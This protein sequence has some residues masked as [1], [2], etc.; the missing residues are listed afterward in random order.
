MKIHGWPVAI[1]VVCINSIQNPK[2]TR[3][4]MKNKRQ[5]CIQSVLI[6]L[7]LLLMNGVSGFAQQGQAVEKMDDL[8]VT[9]TKMGQNP[10]HMTGSVTVISR[11]E[12]KR[13][14]FTDMTE[15]LRF[16]PSVEFKQ[17]GGPG[18]FSYPKMRGY[19]QGHFLVLVNGM[20]IN[21]AY[22]AGVGNFLGHLDT[23]LIDSVEILRGP[24][25]SLYG[26]DTT[27][28]VMA[29]NTLEGEPGFR[30]NAGVEYGS[31]G[32]KKGY[33]TIRG[34]T[35]AWEYALGAVYTDSEGVHDDEYYKNFSPTFKLGWHPGSVDVEFAY[36]YIDSEFQSAQ[37]K[38]NNSFLSSRDEHWAFQTPDPN[39]ANEYE[40]HIATLN[41]SQDISD[42]LRH[43]MVLGWFE[44]KHCRNDLDDGLLGYETAPFD[45]FSFGGET[46]N[47]GDQVPVY[48][49]GTG[50]AYGNDHKNL[51]LDYN[52]I[53]D[54]QL[55][56]NASNSMLFGFEYFYQEGGKWGR[57]GDL[58]SDIYNYSFY[59]NDH[60]LLLGDALVLSAG[61]RRDENEVFGSETTG[62]VGTAYTFFSTGTTFFANY[63]TSFRAPTFFNIYDAVYGNEDLKPETGWT[64]ETGVRQEFLGGR[65]DMEL[66]YWYSE[67]D[68]VVVF[69]YSIPN[70]NSSVGSGKYANRDSA[71]T[72]G[73][74]VIFGLNFTE[75]LS[76]LG[77]YT[78]TDSYSKKEGETFRT[79]Q[80]ARNK[81]NMTLA[82]ENDK[83]NFGVTGYYSGPRL[84][85]KGDLEM[86]AYTRV[87]LFARYNLVDNLSLYSRVENV[88]DEDIEEGL[89]YEQPG[90]YAVIGCEWL[91]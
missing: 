42:A 23:T 31:L 7:S 79:V 51:M 17:A 56:S 38:E 83:Y 27:A 46:Y 72:S 20:K 66:T 9:S 21:E 76:L 29:F 62:K 81:G 39:N 8:V 6:I 57:Y 24:Q 49:D 88:F 71:E 60:L 22:N 30:L 11:E 53:L 14:S 50:V 37:L 55:G 67:L 26:S 89:G 54:S 47:K 16:T 68:D 48:D 19:G 90:V 13:Q 80:I 64:V 36:L 78:Y 2:M 75:E 74:E 32:W 1:L 18:H 40:H 33:S 82:C 63:G 87:D 59:L 84:R 65:M 25:A 45:D 44:K 61:L 52:L 73:V 12:I 58:E 69:D 28:G 85:W 10:E 35:D 34:G 41:A 3:K 4:K 15:I 43:K 91:L 5:V 77:S 86:D 70:P